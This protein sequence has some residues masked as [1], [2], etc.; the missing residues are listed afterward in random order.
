MPR[1]RTISELSGAIKGRRTELGMSQADLAAAAGVS[2]RWIG[3]LEAGKS[4]VELGLTL[5]VLDV[6]RLA[7]SIDG[8]EPESVSDELDELMAQYHRG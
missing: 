8:L 6:L 4:S 3:Q 5:R 2:R 7:I 1:I